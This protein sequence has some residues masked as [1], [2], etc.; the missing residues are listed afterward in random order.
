MKVCTNKKAGYNNAIMDLNPLQTIALLSIFIGLHVL[1][2]PA[3][4]WALRSRQFSGHE[5][6]VWTLDDGE[7]PAAPPAAVTVSARRARWMVGTLATL[8]AAMLGTVVLTLVLALYGSA[9]PAT[10]KCPF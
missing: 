1:A 8:A 9:H 6:Q 3:F 2:L 4:L 5:Q 10:G 7:A